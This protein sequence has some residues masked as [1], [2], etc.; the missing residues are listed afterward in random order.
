MNRH[1]AK[2]RR[3]SARAAALLGLIAGWSVAPASPGAEIDAVLQWSKRVEL[4]TPVS[5]VVV[6]IAADTGQRVAKDH[7]LLRL[8]TKARAA[9]VEQAKAELVRD[10]RL[11]DEAQ[12]EMNRSNDLYAAQLLAEHEMEVVRIALD[13]AQAQYQTAKAQLV[14]AESDLYYSEIR[15]PFDAMVVQ[16]IAEVGQ[17]VASQLQTT[18]LM[19]VAEADVMVA[20]GSVSASAA[21]SIK[22]DQ[23]VVVKFGGRDYEGH[24]IRVGLEP[25]A[26]R[27]ELR[28]PIDVTFG[29]PGVVAR[30]GESAK[31]VLP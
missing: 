17:T 10:T 5:G 1:M 2:R 8:D 4:S 9:K 6:E 12:R 22:P 30:A 26:K 31:I 13:E 27:D 14:Q 16:R 25:V 29:T 18:P 24:V 19:V 28:Y 20:R 11:R 7:V 21:R 15:A 23:K 3:S